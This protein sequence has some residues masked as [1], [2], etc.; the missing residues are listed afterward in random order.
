MCWYVKDLC[1]NRS[2]FLSQHKCEFSAELFHSMALSPL[3]HS[4]SSYSYFSPHKH[5]PDT[6]VYIWGNVSIPKRH[7]LPAAEFKRE[8]EERVEKP[9]KTSSVRHRSE[10]HP[11][12][13]SAS[14][15]RPKIFPDN[16]CDAINRQTE[17]RDTARVWENKHIL[18]DRARGEMN[19]Y[20]KTLDVVI[21][22]NGDA[23]VLFKMI[24]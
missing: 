7:G 13:C 14:G 20:V 22:S 3:H 18:T 8:E 6:P 1:K 16:I 11:N 4:I 2:V 9:S 5:T 19:K 17:S 10:R 23:N 24:F 15:K 12:I 21:I